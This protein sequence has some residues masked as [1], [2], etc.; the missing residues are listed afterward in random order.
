MSQFGLFVE[1]NL[2]AR[3]W[4]GHEITRL[5]SRLLRLRWW[6]W[7]I[8]AKMVNYVI[9]FW[10]FTSS[11]CEIRYCITFPKVG[12]GFHRNTPHCVSGESGDSVQCICSKTHTHTIRSVL[13]HHW[14]IACLHSKEKNMAR[15]DDIGRGHVGESVRREGHLGMNRCILQE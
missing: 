10:H 11:N 2:F 3:R 9:L 13:R 15:I 12:V 6:W 14:L 7:S 5:S 1:G 8:Q 4:L